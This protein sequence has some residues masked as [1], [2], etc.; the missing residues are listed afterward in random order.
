MLGVSLLG[1]TVASCRMRRRQTDPS[2]PD[3]V[4]LE[5]QCTI[6]CYEQATSSDDNHLYSSLDTV[7]QK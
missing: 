5:D 4:Q 2:N 6:N 3:I 1:A 7:G